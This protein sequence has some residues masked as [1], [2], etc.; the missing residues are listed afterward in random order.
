MKKITKGKSVFASALLPLLLQPR[1][2]LAVIVKFAS[3]YI[4]ERQPGF[5][6][7]GITDP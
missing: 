3:G 6:Y 7:L 4:Q 1:N 5:P 2:P